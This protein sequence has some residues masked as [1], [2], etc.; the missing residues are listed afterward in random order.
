M[1]I[2][3]VGL[4]TKA[5]ATGFAIALVAGGAAVATASSAHAEEVTIERVVTC[6]R[7]VG[8]IC[9]QTLVC[10]VQSNGYWWCENGQSGDR[11][12]PTHNPNLD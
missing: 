12:G 9:E 6:Q 7:M 5:M 10:Y 11:R 1:T 4:S 3:R 2:T 8:S